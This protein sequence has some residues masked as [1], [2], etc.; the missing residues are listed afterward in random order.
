M[1]YY[2]QVPVLKDKANWLVGL[3]DD[4]ELVIAGAPK[5]FDDIPE[6]KFLVCAVSNG[7]F[8]AAAVL[9]SRAEFDEFTQEDDQ[10]PKVF[11][12]LSKERTFDLVPDLKREF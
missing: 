12:L 3:Y 11:L 8:E 1:G 7:P 5:T 4:V 6:G 2:I 10:R 9:Y